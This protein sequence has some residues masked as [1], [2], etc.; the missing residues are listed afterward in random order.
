MTRASREGGHQDPHVE[1]GPTLTQPRITQLTDT[2]GPSAA[3][4]VF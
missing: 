3:T 1:A 2:G 4:W